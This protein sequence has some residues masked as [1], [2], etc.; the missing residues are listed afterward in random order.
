MTVDLTGIAVSVIGG[1]FSILALVVSAWLTAHIKNQTAAATVEAAVQNSLGAIQQAADGGIVALHPQVTGVPASL[2][3]G[4]RYVLEQ[5]GPETTR[6]GITPA[7]IA[8][9]IEAK[10][11]LEHI[12]T[13]LALSAS[14]APIVVT[15]L[16]PT[17]R[18]VPE[19]ASPVVVVGS[20][21]ARAQS[22]L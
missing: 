1:G 3:V 16:D 13:N 8:A 4:V 6:L 22:P 9:K 21:G 10:I 17:P 15:P 12:K 5:A 7:A 14:P 11:G 2:A 20:A 19:S 18:V